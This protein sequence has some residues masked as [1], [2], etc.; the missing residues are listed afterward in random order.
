MFPRIG[1]S[2][3]PWEI[4]TSVGNS[5]PPKA[6]PAF[7]NSRSTFRSMGMCAS[8]HSWLRES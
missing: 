7:R 5:S 3:A 8:S 6:T 2:E 4:P 1:E